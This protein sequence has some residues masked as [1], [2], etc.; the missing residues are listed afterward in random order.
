MPLL[1][2]NVPE[3]PGE[4]TIEETIRKQK[5]GHGRNQKPGEV[6]RKSSMAPRKPLSTIGPATITA[7]KAAAAL[8]QPNQAPSVSRQQVATTTA[9][10]RMPSSI[11]IVKKKT[12]Q[13]TNPSPMRHAAAVTTSRTTMGY[14]KGRATSS[15]MKQSI[16]PKKGTSNNAPAE[17]PDTSL[18][19]AAYIQRYGVPPAGSEMWIRCFNYGC[20]DD[21]DEG[22]EDCLKGITPASLF[23]EDDADADFQLVC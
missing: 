3:Y 23:K 18:A 10:S 21:D 2:I 22:L 6:V 19:P 13:P 8:S 14:S 12:L 16:L 20:F 1:G 17:V 15:T 11:L 7:K 4:D 5:M 9:N